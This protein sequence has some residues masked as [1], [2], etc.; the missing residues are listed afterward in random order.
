LRKS[1]SLIRIGRTETV[2]F[3]RKRFSVAH[4][5][6]AAIPAQTSKSH[7]SAPEAPAVMSGDSSSIPFILLFCLKPTLQSGRIC[8]LSAETVC[9]K[10][11]CVS[12]A[13]L[14]DLHGYVVSQ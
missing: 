9:R 12:G 3:G 4:K 10:M 13:L 2:V 11:V 5:D 6:S 1:K 8:N 7:V 14:T